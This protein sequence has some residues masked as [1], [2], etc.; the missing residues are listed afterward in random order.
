MERDHV[1]HREQEHRDRP[2]GDDEPGH[3][4]AGLLAPLLGGRRA[5]A[6]DRDPDPI[7]EELGERQRDRRPE[8][9]AERLAGPRLDA[10][11]GDADRHHR[12][13]D[14]DR[15]IRVAAE[16]EHGRSLTTGSDDDRGR[17]GRCGYSAPA[18]GHRHRRARR[19]RQVN[20]RPGARRAP[21]L[22]LPG[23]RGDVPE[24]RAG[25]DP[26]RDRP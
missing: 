19:G 25:R 1:E 20:G 23:L 9:V 11:E 15:A 4:L 17:R 18:H 21:R 8:D 3:R 6:A 14:V 2:R 7:G 5:A 16:V 10:L 24:R 26:G 22:H 12:D 13:Q